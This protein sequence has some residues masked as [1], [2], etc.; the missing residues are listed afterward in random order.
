MLQ[1]VL[2][3]VHRHH[4]QQFGIQQRAHATHRLD[5]LQRHTFFQLLADL[6]G[7]DSHLVIH[8][9]HVSVEQLCVTFDIRQR[10]QLVNHV[11]QL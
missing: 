8:I 5:H 9:R 2:Q 10:Q 3:Q 1:G 4:A 7:I 6:A 11:Q